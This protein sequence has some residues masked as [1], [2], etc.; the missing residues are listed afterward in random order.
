MATPTTGMSYGDVENIWIQAGGNPQA[1]A[2][3]AAVADA[4]SGLN[5]NVS[6]T[7]PD[8]STSVGLWLLPTNGTPVG[9]TDPLANARAAIQLSNNGADW[10]QWCVTWS[11]NNCGCDDGTYLGQGSNALGSLGQRLS[12]ASYNVIGSAPASD[13]TGA[14]AATATTA[15]TTSTGSGS[16]TSLIIIAIIVIIVG[17]VWWMRQRGEAGGEAPNPGMESEGRS[18]VSWTP[19]EES[20]IRSNTRQGGKTDA[21]LSAQLGRSV[22]SIRVRRN[23]MK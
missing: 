6:R 19:E 13:G 1:A 20:A 7:N 23:Q 14:S 12:P 8:G 10:K 4:S 15:G 11:D 2:M 16:K 22:R 18:Q 21:Q 5:P 9:S 17:L 3:A